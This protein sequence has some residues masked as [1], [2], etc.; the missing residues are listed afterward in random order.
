VLGKETPA[1]KDSRKNHREGAEVPPQKHLQKRAIDWKAPKE[2]EEKYPAKN[3]AE[4]ITARPGRRVTR[5]EVIKPVFQRDCHNVPNRAA[6]KA[7]LM[8]EKIGTESGPEVD[9]L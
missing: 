9:G 2:P 4:G 3:F 7:S 1:G 6:T 8:T 5:K